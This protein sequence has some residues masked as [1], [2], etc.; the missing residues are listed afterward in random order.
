MSIKMHSFCECMGGYSGLDKNDLCTCL[1]KI[2]QNVLRM[3]EISLKIVLI[4]N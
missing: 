1:S 4:K 2:P 3:S